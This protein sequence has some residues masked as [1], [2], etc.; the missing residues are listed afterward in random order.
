MTNQLVFRTWTDATDRRF[1][2][3]FV[4]I[5]R[6]ERYETSHVLSLARAGNYCFNESGDAHWIEICEALLAAGH[7]SF[8][9]TPCS[10]LR[11]KMRWQHFEESGYC[12]VDYEDLGRS[13]REMERSFALLREIGARVEDR[14]LRARRK[15]WEG[16][17]RHKIGDEQMTDPR[18]ILAV[19][20]ARKD[21]IEIETFMSVEVAKKARPVEYTLVGANAPGMAVSA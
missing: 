4:E 15:E 21:A 1:P 14:R 13:M 7:E 18:E 5:R 12:Q 17:S 20:R 9:S 11:I 8:F 19:L 10:D 16:A 6:S 2:Q 3:T